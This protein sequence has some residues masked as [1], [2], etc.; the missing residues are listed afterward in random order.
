MSVARKLALVC[1]CWLGYGCGSPYKSAVDNG[2]HALVSGD[3]VRAL[4]H[5]EQ[6]CRLSEPDDDACKAVAVHRPR[7][8]AQLLLWIRGPCTRGQV[9]ACATPV[10][11]GPA[12]LQNDPDVRRL[13]EVVAAKQEAACQAAYGQERDGLLYRA[14]CMGA[15][16]KL[17]AG[18]SYDQRLA[19]ARLRA[20]ESLVELARAFHANAGASMILTDAALQLTANDTWRAERDRLRESF[21]QQ[22]AIPVAFALAVRAPGYRE[23]LDLCREIQDRLSDRVQCR[24]GGLA[25]DG[26]LLLQPIQTRTWTKQHQTRYQAGTRS[27]P[28]PEYPTASRAVSDARTALRFAEQESAE[29][30]ADCRSATRAWTTAAGDTTRADLQREM[31]RRCNR[32]SELGRVESLRRSDLAD[33]E[34]RLSTTGEFL[35]EPVFEN[36]YWTSVH[37]A[38][39]A[40]YVF[41]IR[42]FSEL[43]R[44]SNTLSKETLEQEGFAPANVPAYTADPPPTIEQMAAQAI[45]DVVEEMAQKVERWTVERGEVR[46]A[47]CKGADI[48]WNAAWLQCRAESALWRGS[49]V[50]G[51]LV[52]SRYLAK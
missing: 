40:P 13:I 42:G 46:A 34:H 29:A 43:F 18:T 11:N 48:R 9:T 25:L 19:N 44:G 7:A 15:H 16:E 31:E 50:D 1:G 22:A 39:S 30:R 51:S 47:D 4:V 14:G 8:K 6:A 35:R 10:R 5:Y 52:L 33:A 49:A 26:E 12:T 17:L 20:S 2:N 24:A 28:N 3:F 27:V 37:H 21:T 36:Y 38:W 45:T 32:E 23:T 41:A